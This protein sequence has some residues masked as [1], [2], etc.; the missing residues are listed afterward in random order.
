MPSSGGDDA[1]QGA[2]VGASYNVALQLGFR[3]LTFVVNA[4]IIRYTSSEMLGVVNVRLTLLYSTI[5]FISREPFRKA[6]LSIS[7]NELSRPAHFRAVINVCWMVI[8]VGAVTAGVLGVVW[9]WALEVPDLPGYGPAV[10]AYALSA[11][12]EL[13]V[14][15]LWVVGQINLYF[16]LK[17][18]AEGVQLSLRCGIAVLLLI[19]MPGV[20]LYGFCAAQLLSSLA[21]VAVY[22]SAFARELAKKPE[23]I[24]ATTLAELLPGPSAQTTG[25]WFLELDA[26]MTGRVIGF[27]KQSLLKQFLTEGEGYLMTFLGVLSFSEQGVYNIVN[28]LGS[29]VARFLFAPIEETFFTYFAGKLNAI[30]AD[31]SALKKNVANVTEAAKTLQTLGTFVGLVSI[32]I[33][34]FAQPYSSLLLEL[35]GGAWL[36]DGEGPLLLRTYAVYVVLLAANGLTECFMTASLTNA[37]V[38]RHNLWMVAFT[39]IFLLASWQ[40]TASFG[41]VGF[42]L[43]NCVNM[44]VRIGRSSYMIVTYLAAQRCPI[45]PLRTVWPSWLVVL[46]FAAALAV[47]KISEDVLCCSVKLKAGHVGVGVLAILTVAATIFVAE[48]QFL[49]DFKNDLFGRPK[50]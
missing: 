27:W 32:T 23:H 3:L 25:R 46:A 40:L 24:P 49:R 43:A 37:Q 10:A 11:V 19:A 42:I 29:L 48:K 41:A 50:A 20:G 1:L 15:P 22:C 6:M 36:S 17:V 34:V 5:L 8:P 21:L 12:I 7:Q 38:E 35:Y 14:E 47:T 18:A 28:N 39:A 2:S 45:N 9:T 44:T 30:D 26:G 33:A 13:L 4:I 31:P 16:K